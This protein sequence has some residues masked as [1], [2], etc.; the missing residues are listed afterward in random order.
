V[1]GLGLMIGVEFVKDRKTKEPHPALAAELQ[2]KA[3]AK[4]L[5][6]LHCGRSTIRISPP[7]VLNA[8]DVDAGL[9][10]LGECLKSL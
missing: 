5:L 10:I 6:V 9:E 1:R 8:H 4:G 7:L 3:F 2:Q